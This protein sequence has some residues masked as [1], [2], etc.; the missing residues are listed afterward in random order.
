LVAARIPDSG[1]KIFLVHLLIRP[2]SFP[3]GI[4]H[5]IDKTTRAANIVSQTIAISA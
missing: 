2:T 3:G 1:A 5:M 4:H